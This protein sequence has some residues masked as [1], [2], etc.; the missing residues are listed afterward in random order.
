MIQIK[1]IEFIIVVNVNQV[2]TMCYNKQ[3]ELLDITYIDNTVFGYDNVL[4]VTING[5]EI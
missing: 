2:K 4:K 3:E 5:E 1:T